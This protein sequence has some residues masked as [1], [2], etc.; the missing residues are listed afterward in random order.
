MASVISALFKFC[1]T[2]RIFTYLKGFYNTGEVKELNNLVKL[3]G[4]FRTQLAYHRF[5]TIVCLVNRV[6]PA[7]I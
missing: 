1:S 5:L 7:Y 3:K 4:K 2:N 6:V